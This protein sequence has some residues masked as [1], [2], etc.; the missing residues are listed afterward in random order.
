[1]ARQLLGI[2]LKDGP[3]TLFVV[4]KKKATVLMA[5]STLFSNQC[6]KIFIKNFPMRSLRKVLRKA[7]SGLVKGER[8]LLIGLVGA[9]R[10]FGTTFL[11]GSCRF[12]P[13]CSAYAVEAINSLPP[14]RACLLIIARI[15]KCR[16]GGDFGFDPVPRDERRMPS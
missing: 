8:I 2:D 11:G 6:R 16:P 4:F 14:N 9:Y 7:G 1:M 10:T 12:E 5:I 15:F 3:G 13:S